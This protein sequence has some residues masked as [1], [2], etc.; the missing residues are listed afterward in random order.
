MVRGRLVLNPRGRPRGRSG[1][2]TFLAER[3]SP[4]ARAASA[5]DTARR[6]LW[7]TATRTT[8]ADLVST[9][10][11][12]PA[13]VFAPPPPPLRSR[14]WRCFTVRAASARAFFHAPLP[15]RMSV[16]LPLKGD[17]ASSSPLPRRRGDTGAAP[18]S[19]RSEFAFGANARGQPLIRAASRPGPPGADRPSG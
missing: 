11:S 17:W 2:P 6:R 14:R 4:G 13:A 5:P 12:R 9:A 10:P 3:T 19:S 1:W 15:K 8:R 16:G 18:R 7:A